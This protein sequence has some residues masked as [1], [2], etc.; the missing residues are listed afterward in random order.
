MANIMDDQTLLQFQFPLAKT[1]LKVATRKNIHDPLLVCWMQDEIYE[2][3]RILE[4][5]GSLEWLIQRYESRAIKNVRS[6][7]SL[8]ITELN[9]SAPEK[10]DGTFRCTR[11]LKYVGDR[12]RL[13][14]EISRDH[15]S[16]AGWGIWG[17]FIKEI[18]RSELKEV[19]I[20]HDNQENTSARPTYRI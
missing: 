19:K 1:E 6:F 15:I 14:D 2:I 18:Y 8:V 10:G 16:A 17:G 13:E 9:F 7:R 4:Y 11:V 5:K 3:T 20:D 12:Y